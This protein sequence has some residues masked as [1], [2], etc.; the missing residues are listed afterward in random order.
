MLAVNYLLIRCY[1]QGFPASAHEPP[2]VLRGFERQLIK[3]GQSAKFS[4]SLR[5][6]DIS[7]W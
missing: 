2:R 1:K 3:K 7:I 5:V 6:K 4:I